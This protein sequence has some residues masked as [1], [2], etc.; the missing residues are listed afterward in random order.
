M[1][2]AQLAHM[3]NR[4]WVDVIPEIMPLFNEM[5]QENHGYSASQIM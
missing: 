5:D 1:I 4:D 2:Q 3:G